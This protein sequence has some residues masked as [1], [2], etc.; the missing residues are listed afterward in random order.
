MV[1]VRK[2]ETDDVMPAPNVSLFHKKKLK[3]S[4]TKVKETHIIKSRHIV[5]SFLE[6]MEE[7]SVWSNKNH[8]F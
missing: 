1:N 2:E 8:V 6:K 7:E 5:K 3:V 4:S